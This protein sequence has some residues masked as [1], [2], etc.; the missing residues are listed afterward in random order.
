MIQTLLEALNYK[1]HVLINNMRR[2]ADYFSGYA[3]Q[4]LFNR[5]NSGYPNRIILPLEKPKTTPDKE[6]Q[7]HLA[8]NGWFVHNYTE[9]LA[10]K[11]SAD[12]D[13]NKKLQLKSI[14]KVLQ[15]TGADK[16]NHSQPL[17]RLI[18]GSDGQPIVGSNG[19][20]KNEIVPQSLLH[21]YN[22][23]KARDS[24]RHETN[25]IISRDVD[26]IG[27]MS[28]GRTWEADSCMRLPHSDN[29]D[30]R[31][32]DAGAYHKK[33]K[34]DFKHHTLVVYATKKGDTAIENP[35]GRV[36]LKKFVSPKKHVIYRLGSKVYG[37]PP[38]EFH[39]AVKKF[40]EDNWP[41]HDNTTYKLHKDLY[42]DTHPVANTP[43]STGLQK[44][45][46]G[47]RFLNKRGHLEDFTDEN[48]IRQP[49]YIN[50]NT[51]VITTTHFKDGERH[52]ENGVAETVQWPN[53]S[54]LSTP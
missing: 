37:N 29:K 50:N 15:Q 39:E 14:G 46:D 25:M 53:G 48:G 49:A 43:Y 13:G 41:A 36:L 2:D 28:S 33:I 38:P 40:S 34:Q 19:R 10:G 20:M 54:K 24:A 16:I 47:H 51:G 45:P 1:Q 6:I 26:D 5:Y 12:R 23:D 44:Y 52:N 18:K 27:G 22:N 32:N 3:H 8:K 30:H 42:Q 17:D 31:C 4:D 35:L 21:F 9:G 11:Y 7:K